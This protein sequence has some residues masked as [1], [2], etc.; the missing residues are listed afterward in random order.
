MKR[1]DWTPIYMLIVVIIAAIVI[2]AIVKPLFRGAAETAGQNLGAASG[3][4]RGAL[5]P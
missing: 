5:F 4:A 3:I 2:L 1:G